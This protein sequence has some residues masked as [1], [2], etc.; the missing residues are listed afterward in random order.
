MLCFCP[1]SPGFEGQ[2]LFTSKAASIEGLWLPPACFPSHLDKEDTMSSSYF[3]DI[4][5]PETRHCFKS[6]VMGDASLSEIH[7]SLGLHRLTSHSQPLPSQS[8]CVHTMLRWPLSTFSSLSF[9]FQKIKVEAWKEDLRKI[10]F[11]CMGIFHINK[12]AFLALCTFL[13]SPFS[14]SRSEI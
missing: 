10:L 11:P 14:I 3:L 9:F 6:K 13:I 5:E 4:Q 1:Q 8:S 2:V 12:E 7:R